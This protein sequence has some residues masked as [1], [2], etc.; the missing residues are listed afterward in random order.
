MTPEPAH[1]S[2]SKLYRLDE[3]DF[4]KTA[5]RF[6][7]KIHG[8]QPSTRQK[9]FLTS[10]H[11]C[12]TLVLSPISPVD[13]SPPYNECEPPNFSFILIGKTRTAGDNRQ[14]NNATSDV[15]DDL[16]PRNAS[17][18]TGAI[19]YQRVHSYLVCKRMVYPLP[20]VVQPIER[21]TFG[22]SVIAP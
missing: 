8:T 19:M 14:H 9:L 21:E 22:N 6:S 15:R 16:Q 13:Y 20:S 17:L 18:A 1:K 11:L 10:V 12:G 5:V 7:S 4:K 2:G 3:L